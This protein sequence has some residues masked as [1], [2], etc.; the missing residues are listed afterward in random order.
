MGAKAAEG[1]DRLTEG[2]VSHGERRFLAYLRERFRRH[3]DPGLVCDV[4]CRRSHKDIARCGGGHEDSLAQG[5]RQGK[6]GV[7]YVAA[8]G[9]VEHV[10][11]AA[12]GRD[13]HVV[14][15]LAYEV[16]QLVGMDAG[17][18]D[19]CMGVERAP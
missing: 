19:D 17:S 12:A 16:V 14:G 18:V 2:H 11:L 4:L 10:V 9:R 13:R 8:Y 6:D 5:S 1:A 3:V 15:S 7:L